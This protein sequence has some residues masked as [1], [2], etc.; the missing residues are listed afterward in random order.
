MDYLNELEVGGK[1]AHEINVLI[2]DLAEEVRQGSV[3]GSVSNDK[4][5]EACMKD[6]EFVIA[7]MRS[8]GNKE[9]LMLDEMLNKKAYQMLLDQYMR[10]NQ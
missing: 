6:K 1:K 4:V 10:E 5:I 7:L 3:I 9:Q 2:L 8:W